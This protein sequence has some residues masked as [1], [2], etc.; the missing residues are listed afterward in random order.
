MVHFKGCNVLY[1]EDF[2]YHADQYNSTTNYHLKN[3]HQFD[4]VY[5]FKYIINFTKVVFTI[6]LFYSIALK[7]RGVSIFLV[8]QC[9]TLGSNAQLI[10][11]LK[12]ALNL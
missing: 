1:S 4:A 9:I 7:C 2:Q 11:S 5:R 3:V 6:I 12:M 8:T 10:T